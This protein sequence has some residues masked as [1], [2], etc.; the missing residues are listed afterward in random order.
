MESQIGRALVCGF[1]D[2]N[3]AEWFFG[4]NVWHNMP[5]SSM[6]PF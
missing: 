4:M 3:A 1:P 5:W 6:F 2:K